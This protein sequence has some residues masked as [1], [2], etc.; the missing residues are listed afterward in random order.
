MLLWRGLAVNSPTKYGDALPANA[1]FWYRVSKREVKLRNK[2]YRR[3]KHTGSIGPRECLEFEIQKTVWSYRMQLARTSGPKTAGHFL[4][5]RASVCLEGASA[6]PVVINPRLVR[7]RGV[8]QGTGRGVPGRAIPPTLCHGTPPRI[9]ARAPSVVPRSPPGQSGP[10]SA[11]TTGCGC[12]QVT[13]AAAF[14]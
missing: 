11:A 6:E 8:N 5:H 4:V 13:T 9:G 7:H 14:Y 12:R 3:S 1:G 10:R 2:R